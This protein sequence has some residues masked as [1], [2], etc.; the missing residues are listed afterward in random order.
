[1]KIK[2][3][4]ENTSEFIKA[5]PDTDVWNLVAQMCEKFEFKKGVIGGDV[6]DMVNTVRNLS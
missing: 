6:R 5:N 1:M 4:E 3:T 2:A